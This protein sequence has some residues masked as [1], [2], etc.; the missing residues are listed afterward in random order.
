[1]TSQPETRAPLVDVL[2]LLCLLVLPA[3]IVGLVL[4]VVSGSEDLVAGIVI[5]GL[6]GA[7]LAGLR[8]G[9]YAVR[10]ED[11]IKRRLRSPPEDSDNVWARLASIEYDPKYDR[12]LTLILFTV[13]L[14][15][16]A[17]IP[18]VGPQNGP[19]ILRLVFV[20]LFGLTAGLMTYGVRHA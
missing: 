19:L 17:A 1:M 9:F 13:G 6:F 5:G 4:S 11:G 3:L 8:R 20:G 16:F 12:L 15:S 14:G 2:E 7:I 18:F 10:T